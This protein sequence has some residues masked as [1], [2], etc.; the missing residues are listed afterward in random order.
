[1]NKKY[2]L[3]ASVAAAMGLST[4]AL[5]TEFEV[6]IVNLTP[7]MYFTPLIV[8]AHTPS[9]RMFTAGEVASTELQSIA[10]GGN[11]GPMAELLEGI[12]AD[13]ATGDGLLAPGASVSFT[14]DDAGGNSVLSLSSMLLPTNDA[15]VGLSAIPFPQ[16]D[17]GSQR[18]YDAIAYDAGTEANDELIGS[19]EPG[20]AGFPAPPPVVA[21]GLG[22][23]GTGINAPVE[24][25]ISVHKGTIGDLDE[26]G[27][28]SDINQAVHGWLN[29]VARVTVTILGDSV[30]P[31]NGGVEN[32]TGVTYS[33]TAVEIF[34]EA[35]AG[36]AAGTEYEVSRDGAVVATTDG[37]SFFDASLEPGSSVVYTV[38]AT[39]SSDGDAAVTLVTNAQ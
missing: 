21:S 18:V 23:N 13:V 17:A 26:A 14:V 28:V 35:V 10:E 20:V 24:G 37:F 25:F 3:A 11:V 7:A 34:W 2:Q 36:A 39:D 1:M 30:A 12:G 6:T 5:A 31:G 38:R 27:G 16:G 9:A 32:L 33:S 29:P 22:S 4:P 19:G 15:F 8:A